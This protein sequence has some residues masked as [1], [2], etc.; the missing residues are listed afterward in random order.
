MLFG[1]LS[2]ALCAIRLPFE[3][4]QRRIQTRILSHCRGTQVELAIRNVQALCCYSRTQLQTWAMCVGVRKREWMD[5]LGGL[6]GRGCI[7]VRMCMIMCVGG[8]DG[9]SV[10]WLVH[11]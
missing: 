9:W 6:L 8:C 7:P 10:L 11:A 5:L 1:L 2:H 3:N 4:C